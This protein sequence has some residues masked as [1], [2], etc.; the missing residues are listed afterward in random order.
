MKN[1][2]ERT[3]DALGQRSVARHYR[4]RGEWVFSLPAKNKYLA[5]LRALNDLAVAY[6]VRSDLVGDPRDVL[7]ALSR[8]RQALGLEPGLAEAAFN[9]Q[10][11]LLEQLGL[12]TA[13]LGAWQ[14][15][16][17]RHHEGGWATKTAYRRMR[18]AQELRWSEGGSAFEQ[19]ARTGD[20]RAKRLA[21]TNPQAAFESGLEIRG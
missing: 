21:H 14:S 20:C 8:A 6:G 12:N 11:L 9:Q 16:L 4:N 10:A 13:A 19:A 17:E 15:Y 1:T 2:E 7:R 3:I 5:N 18:I